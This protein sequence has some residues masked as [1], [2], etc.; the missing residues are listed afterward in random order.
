MKD[1]ISPF[2]QAFAEALVELAE[3]E[4]AWLAENYTPSA[5]TAELPD[6]PALKALKQLF[7]FDDAV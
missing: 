7:P 3:E 1:T 6:S 5:L 4:E 2:K